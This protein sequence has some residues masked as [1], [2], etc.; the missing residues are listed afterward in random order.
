MLITTA[1]GSHQLRSEYVNNINMIL[2]AMFM[3]FM[4]LKTGC[5]T[6]LRQQKKEGHSNASPDEDG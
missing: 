6:T 5:K 3:M 1:H 2:H 4:D